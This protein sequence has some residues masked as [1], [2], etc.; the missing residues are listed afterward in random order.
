MFNIN[1]LSHNS[2]WH[3]YLIYHSG[4]FPLP[5][6][7][8]I[9]ILSIAGIFKGVWMFLARVES[10]TGYLGLALVFVGGGARR[11]GFGRCFLE[12]FC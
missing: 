11:E 3:L 6:G 1:A 5:H 10:V 9:G 8:S 12:L 7:L 2:L 4:C